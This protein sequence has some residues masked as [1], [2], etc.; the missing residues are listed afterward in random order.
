M[1]VRA[2][3]TVLVG[4]CAA[5]NPIALAEE[6][7]RKA[8]V[9]VEAEEFAPL[10]Q[11]WRAGERWAD[12]IYS[13]TSADGVLVNDGGGKEEVHK[14]I[15][16]P[17]DGT[18]HV[19]VRYLK[20]GEYPGSFGLRI[21]QNGQAVFDQKYRTQPKKTSWEPIWEKFPATLKAG[22]ATLAI[23][24]AQPGIR[25]RI[26]CVL[27]TSRLD[28]GAKQ[29]PDYRDFG[30]QVFFR[31]RFTE[32]AVATA[33]SVQSYIRRGPV[34]YNDLG[35]ATRTGL[36]TGGGENPPDSW[37]P[38]YEIT[39]IVDTD[40][41][42]AT[43]HLH[44]RSAGQAVPRAKLDLQVAPEPGDQS[45]QTL[46]E[47]LDGDIVTVLVPGNLR[48]YPDALEMASRNTR[49]HLE[50]ARGFVG[51]SAQDQK[52]AGIKLETYVCGF[53]GHY[54]SKR[55]LAEEME[56]AS[57][58]GM[59][60]FQDLIGVSRQ[61]AAA[62]GITQT[63]LNR[64]IP[65]QTF[66]CPT[67]AENAKII[68]DYYRSEA[69]KLRKDDPETL[70]NAYRN[71]LYDEPGTGNLDHIAQCESCT[72]AFRE[73]LKQRHLAPAEFGKTGW[74]QVGV[75]T[76]DAATDLASK[77]LYYW[78]VQFR[79]ASMAQVF[80]WGTDMT[81]KYLGPQIWA[82][83][84]FTNGGLSDWA[85]GLID[86]PDWFLVGRERAQ[87]MMWSEDWT[88]LGPDGTGYAVDMLRSAGSPHRLPVGMYLIANDAT[89]LPL[90]T[91][92][93]LMHGAKCLNFYCY[94]PY[95]A[96]ADGTLS[97]NVPAQRA[98]ATVAREIAKA[99]HLLAPGHVPS[100]QVA[101][102]YFKS[103]EIWQADIAIQ[104]ERRNTY[105][106]L[107]HEN[108]PVDFLDEPLVEQGSLGRY[109]VLHLV[110]SNVSRDAAVKIRDW[111]A[112]GGTLVACAGAGLRDEYDE[113]LPTLRDVFGVRDVSVAK[114]KMSYRE[115]YDLPGAK[116]T[117]TAAIPAAA[118]FAAAELPV[119]GYRETIA[120]STATVAAAFSNQQPAALVNAF[121]KGRCLRFGFLPAVSYAKDGKPSASQVAVGY[122][123]AERQVITAGA[124]WAKVVRP[125]VC[126]VA[127]VEANLL[128]SSKGSVALLANWT[129]QP[130]PSLTVTVRPN[131]PVQSVESIK[132]GRLPFKSVDGGIEVMLPLGATD[133]LLLQ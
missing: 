106:G 57:L 47:D 70:R 129:M 114:P 13:P 113:E 23:Y 63:Y 3:L 12:D 1:N 95:Y 66:A 71:K 49:K 16:V 108:Y 18:Y 76:R 82:A 48:K 112:Q 79:D 55:M 14:D 24:I 54:N 118:P 30:P 88:S 84:N 81:A 39:K 72:A 124:R 15:T 107:T 123:D 27:L 59:N 61:T 10:S 132:Q 75:I 20:I 90:R 93:A 26:D 25:Q 19:W 9:F 40:K 94:G 117:E 44:F 34:Y 2:I 6:T 11:V 37:S 45:G 28:Y 111:V 110:D 119:I 56:V 17:A 120:P 33:A 80:K 130:I 64:W 131:G 92:S 122:V 31:Y 36:G 104:V 98:L 97:E 85:G 8:S 5:W 60:A 102:S 125:V 58:L 41:Y 69:E 115:R 67:K 68:E 87:S 121:G 100:A 62:L 116:P 109:Q 77:R 42:I 53:G 126:S 83:V 127:R 105:L 51:L 133:M 43:V 35:Y 4:S 103:H 52:P 78:S 38:W 65:H 7:L 22:P 128:S 91:Y 99:D 96:F 74:D 101:V 32:P 73:Y 21:T 46:H 89:T 29:D 50:T 86:G